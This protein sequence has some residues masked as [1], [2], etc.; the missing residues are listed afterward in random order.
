[1]ARD[2]FGAA[3]ADF[4]CVAGGVVWCWCSDCP[5][6][7]GFDVA[8]DGYGSVD[9]FLCVCCVDPTVFGCV[10]LAYGDGVGFFSD[11][12]YFDV[13]AYVCDAFV[14]VVVACVPDVSAPVMVCCFGYCD[15]TAARCGAGV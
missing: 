6:V 10:S 5:S 14:F 8:D 4:V 13:F 3:P 9:W 11:A 15:F 2:A 7:C 12:S 1:M